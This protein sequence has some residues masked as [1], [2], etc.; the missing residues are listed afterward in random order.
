MTLLP[1]FSPTCETWG[2]NWGFLWL[3]LYIALSLVP[4][5][6]VQ[7]NRHRSTICYELLPVGHLCASLLLLLNHMAGSFADA[8]FIG[9]RMSDLPQNFRSR[10]FYK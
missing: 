3:A 5:F 10:L 9:A 2:L 6:P 7:R 1:C 4:V 8:Y